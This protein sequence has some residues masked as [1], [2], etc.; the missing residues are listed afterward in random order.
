MLYLCL[1]ARGLTAFIIS[2]QF[3]RRKQSPASLM[4]LTANSE[5]PTMVRAMSAEMIDHI[6]VCFADHALK[7]STS[8]LSHSGTSGDVEKRLFVV[9]T[10]DKLPHYE[11][12][13]RMWT[14]DTALNHSKSGT[15]TLRTIYNHI[16]LLLPDSAIRR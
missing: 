3:G 10:S 14:N 6:S 7:A 11:A 13:P 4:L 15:T 8:P 12:Y 5:G 2:A 1:R 9:L 16:L